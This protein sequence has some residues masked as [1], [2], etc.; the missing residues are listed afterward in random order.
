MFRSPEGRILLMRRTDTGEWAFPAGHIEK[1][2]TP[3]QAAI[4]EV[5]EETGYR[6]GHSGSWLMRQIAGDVD[7][8]TFLYDCES[9]FTP[10]LNHEH[11]A[12]MWMAPD[13]A[14]SEGKSRADAS[15][16]E[17]KHP[18]G[19]D[20][21]FASI[22]GS[23]AAPKSKTM[24]K[25]GE[26][27]GSMPGG[28]Y[29]EAGGGAGE[30]EYV[31]FY[32]DPEQSKTEALSGEVLTQMGV[33]NT[34]PQ[35]Q[36]T[37]GKESVAAKWQDVEP[38]GLNSLLNDDFS[39]ANKEE[40]A[41]IFA[42]AVMTNNWDVTGID[43]NNLALDSEGHIVQMDLGGSFEFRAQGEGKPYAPDATLATTL[44][45]PQ[46]P[47][48]KVFSKLF[49]ENPGML[50]TAADALANIDPDKVMWAFKKSGLK[51]A[52]QLFE[53]FMTRRDA[54]LK[55]LASKGANPVMKMGAGK[56]LVQPETSP[57][58]AAS[59]VAAAT[60]AFESLAAKVTPEFKA[61]MAAFSVGVSKGAKGAEY[62]ALM[63]TMKGLAPP[64]YFD[65]KATM[66]KAKKAEAQA[67]KEAKE[68]AKAPPPAA[69]E[70]VAPVAPAP[71]PAGHHPPSFDITTQ[72]LTPPAEMY[73][74]TLMSMQAISKTTADKL[75]FTEQLAS[76]AQGFAK[77]VLD[78]EAAFEHNHDPTTY[79][80]KLAKL[81]TYNAGLA[82]A[83]EVLS[84]IYT[85]NLN[86]SPKDK[87][88]VAQW[89]KYQQALD[90]FLG[91]KAEVVAAKASG[92]PVQ[93]A[94]AIE[95]A[96]AAK[97][98]LQTHQA[99]AT[100]KPGPVVN[101]AYANFGLEHPD[102]VSDV[103]GNVSIAGM[104]RFEGKSAH[105]EFVKSMNPGKLPP[106]ERQAISDYKGSGYSGVNSQLRSGKGITAENSTKAT[107]LTKA[108]KRTT[109]P[110]NTV[111]YRG[112]TNY[113]EAG[114]P[115]G[116]TPLQF[117]K[118]GQMYFDNGFVSAT[119][120]KKIAGH[121][122]LGGYGGADKHIVFEYKCTKPITGAPIEGTI[123]DHYDGEQ[124]IVLTRG[125]VFWKPTGYR[126]E[127][128]DGKNVHVLTMESH[129]VEP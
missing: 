8:T 82:A 97:K 48:G 69:P 88:K 116:M 121:W 102:N 30:K 87:A 3:S 109:V 125:K 7:F 101:Q 126:K 14:M 43:G 66:T 25:V 96:I 20:G 36:L 127:T 79:K 74:S 21:K 92:D 59:P 106:S 54:A 80:A 15:W 91:V 9:E 94:A 68:A 93:K 17:G 46:Y 128:I 38:I 83:T 23:G 39:E 100:A 34:K 89:D 61:A 40:L 33:D 11:D 44:V 42:G 104:S 86:A 124:E 1:G 57:V 12:Y 63:A 64:G 122:N 118:S 107:N 123:Y 19:P 41:K 13:D 110:V 55:L 65:A 58:V 37:N 49:D 53:N 51:N 90:T 67:K 45:D 115:E 24:T 112:V 32:P 119:T 72:G 105:S 70:P 111:L 99:L 35:F 98:A 129:E 113:N 71:A 77:D 18:R 84:G 78:A 85:D 2:E 31:K 6:A 75:K 26:Q 120:S 62:Q 103:V 28:V 76:G 117:L 56:S 95:K 29:K 5:W 10:K 50:N 4:R 108:T 27:K 52:E 47:A 73:A 81:A 22:G 114:L 16:E 60:A